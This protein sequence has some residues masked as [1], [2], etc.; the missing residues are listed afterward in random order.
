ME[1]KDQEATLGKEFQKTTKEGASS[2]GLWKAKQ[3]WGP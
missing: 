3:I 1:E 2:Q